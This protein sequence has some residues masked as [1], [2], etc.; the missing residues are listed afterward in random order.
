MRHVGPTRVELGTRTVFN[1]LGPLSN[2]GRRQAS[3]DRRVRPQV[4]RAHGG[5]P[6]AISAPSASGSSTANDVHRRADH[7]RGRPPLSS[8]TAGNHPPLSRSRRRTPACRAPRPKTSRAA[9]PRR[10]PPSSAPCSRARPARRATSCCSM[11]AARLSSSPGAPAIS[12]KASTIAAEAVDS[13]KAQAT[14]DR[15]V[16]ISGRDAPAEAGS[17]VGR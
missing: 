10:T 3:G 13:G 14:L 16:E 1:L 9:T 5:G 2:P 4:G 7:T 17:A 8:W 6:C 15:L 11:P 12:G